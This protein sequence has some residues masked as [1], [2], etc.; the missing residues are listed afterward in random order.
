MKTFEKPD[1]VSAFGKFF[2]NVCSQILSFPSGQGWM[3][4]FK[5]NLPF[6]YFKW[7]A[8]WIIGLKLTERSDKQT[9]KMDIPCYLVQ[10][11]L[12]KSFSSK[13]SKACKCPIKQ[14]SCSNFQE[15]MKSLSKINPFNSVRFNL[16]E[17]YSQSVFH[18]Q[19]FQ[20]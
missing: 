6:Y 7:T 3:L 2:A 15:S 14:E 17:T 13:F 11:D 16:I 5:G 12:K 8:S 1:C 10:F 20:S 4:D 19:F 9:S 18:P